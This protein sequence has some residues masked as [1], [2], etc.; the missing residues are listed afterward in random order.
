MVSSVGPSAASPGRYFL[1]GCTCTCSH[2]TSAPIA[3]STACPS[4][5]CCPPRIHPARLRMPPACPRRR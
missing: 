3:S 5:A 1:A 2:L 4:S